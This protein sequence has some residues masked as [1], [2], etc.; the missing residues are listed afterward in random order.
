MTMAFWIIIAC[1]V[2]SLVY[3]IWAYGQVMAAPAGNERMRSIAA[4]VQEGAQAPK[5]KIQYAEGDNVRVVDGPFQSF[6]GT[7]EEV[8]GDKGKVRVQISIF[9]R[10]TPVTLDFMQV[11]KTA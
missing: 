11:E 3:G 7:V 5:P 2:L 8:Y 6:T 10:A 1:G 4:A 9:G